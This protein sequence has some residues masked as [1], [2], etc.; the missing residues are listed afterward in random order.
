MTISNQLTSA[1]YEITKEQ[2][3][4]MNLPFS[5]LTFL[6]TNEEHRLSWYETYDSIIC[7]HVTYA[8]SIEYAFGH[9]FRITYK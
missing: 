9:P 3:S 7:G 8:Q 6:P 4:Y 1:L 5:C 2:N